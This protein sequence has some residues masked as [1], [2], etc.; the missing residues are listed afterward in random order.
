M[1]ISTLSDEML[2]R[3]WSPEKHD[4]E[5]KNSCL[6]ELQEHCR[7]S[8]NNISE[9]LCG[10]R[11]MR[12]FPLKEMRA[13]E[14]QLEN[15]ALR[16]TLR[17]VTFRARQFNPNLPPARVAIEIQR[18]P[19]PLNPDIYTADNLSVLALMEN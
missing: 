17:D 11:A 19:N 16:N 13:L 3:I 6:Q 14:N 12:N 7:L 10:Q 2:S 18:P 1:T 8:A 4:P 5:W 15:S 9:W